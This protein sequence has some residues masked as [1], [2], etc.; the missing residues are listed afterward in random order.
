M[1][2][3]TD[4]TIDKVESKMQIEAFDLYYSLG[5]ERSLKAVANHYGK[6][7]R[8][9]ANWSRW[10][11]WVE[12]CTQRAIEESES[13][14]KKAAQIDVKGRYRKLF[15]NLI[16]EAIKD[17]NNG[18]LRIKNVLDLERIAKIDLA[19]LDIPS[20]VIN[21]DMNLKPEDKEAIDSLLNTI[22][23]GL[24]SLRE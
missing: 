18:K 11:N 2:E 19:L 24:N 12:R 16:I 21:G 15:N 4:K 14:E 7:E 9:I 3:N 20:E 1:D 8:T 23:S 22:K 17:F 10:F 13:K 6:S 5:N